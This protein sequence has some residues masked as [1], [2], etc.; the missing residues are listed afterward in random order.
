MLD[1]D[2]LSRLQTE[3]KDVALELKAQLQGL[4]DASEPVILDQQS[5]GRV[6]RIDAIQQQQMAQASLRQ[7]TKHLQEI[8]EALLRMATDDYGWCEDCGN[9]IGFARLMIKPEAQFCILCAEKNA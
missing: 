9:D 1:Q 6:S 7:A 3:L 2:Q 8:N 4:T 5:V